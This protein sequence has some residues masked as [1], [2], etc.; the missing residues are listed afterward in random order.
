MQTGAITRCVCATNASKM[1]C[2]KTHSVPRVICCSSLISKAFSRSH[3]HTYMASLTGVTECAS[4]ITE[5][6]H[7]LGTKV[8]DFLSFALLRTK[9]VQLLMRSLLIIVA[10]FRKVGGDK[11]H[12]GML[13]DTQRSFTFPQHVREKRS[14]QGARKQLIRTETQV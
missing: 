14:W 11:S 13:M 10:V 9:N 12:T 8:E 4:L 5:I 7:R 6:L 2:V 1:T 3:T